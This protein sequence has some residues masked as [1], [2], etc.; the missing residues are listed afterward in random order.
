MVCFWEMPEVL[1]YDMNLLAEFCN[2]FYW[3]QNE[4]TLLLVFVQ[5]IT[6]IKV[7]RAQNHF[8]VVHPKRI[9]TLHEVKRIT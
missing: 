1:W 4:R 8:D 2:K 6:E 3:L 9:A 7:M 5:K